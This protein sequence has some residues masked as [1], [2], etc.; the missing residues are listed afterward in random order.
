MRNTLLAR[1]RHTI[2]AHQLLPSRA[3]VVLAVSG[4][5][6][7]IALLQLFTLLKSER[8]L[9]L[10][11]AHLDHGLREES[12]QDAEF[13]RRVAARWDVPA[14]IE[15]RDIRAR[16]AAEG[17]SLEDGARRIRYAFLLEVARR[18]SATHLATAHTADDQAETVL[19]RLLRGTGLLGLGAIPI[20]RPLEELSVIRPLLEVWRWEIDAHLARFKLTPRH[21]A[22]NADPR[23]LRNRVRHHLLPL[24]EREYNPNIK[25]ALAQLA[26]QSRCDYAYLQQ[27]A[28]RQW[29]R[30]VKPRRPSELVIPIQAFLRQPKALQR[31]LVR[32]TVLGLRGRLD[33]FEFRHWTEIERLF[34]EKP[35]GTR[36]DLPGGVVLRREPERVVCHAPA[37]SLPPDPSEGSPSPSAGNNSDPIM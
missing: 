22:S 28:G 9:T 6:D 13:V 20:T 23:F 31:Q 8:R 15:R 4:G 7:S 26:E 24:L 1:V 14:T 10:H 37:H 35:V 27:A 30:T 12:Q 18:H 33:A 36:L 21:D 29:K 25:G 19:M 2:A 3:R 32:Q 11:V 16:C 34:R 17:W 5:A